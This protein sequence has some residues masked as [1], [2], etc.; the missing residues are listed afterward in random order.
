M[1]RLTLPILRFIANCWQS[2]GVWGD[3][4]RYS[5]IGLLCLLVV[6]DALFFLGF[7]LHCLRMLPL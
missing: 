7:T 4:R 1:V 5:T 2:G 3:L 6:S